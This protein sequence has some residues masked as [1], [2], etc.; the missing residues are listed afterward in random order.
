M[1]GA[2]ARRGGGGN[3]AL[4]EEALNSKVAQAA[5]GLKWEGGERRWEVVLWVANE[6]EVE[7]GGGGG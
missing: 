5:C 7:G 1:C 6:A 3:V 4:G 2:H